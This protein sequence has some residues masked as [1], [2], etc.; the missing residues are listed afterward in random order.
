MVDIDK[1]GGNEG[2]QAASVVVMLQP[3]HSLGLALARALAQEGAHLL[4][5]DRNPD[6]GEIMAR[7]LA[8]E[9]IN[10]AFRLL[11]TSGTGMGGVASDLRKVYGQIEGV[12]AFHEPVARSRKL[13]WLS[14][15]QHVLE[16]LFAS[17]VG[18]RLKFY[19]ALKNGFSVA[20]G[21]VVNVYMGESDEQWV[22]GMDGA[23]AAM[24]QTL[25]GPD[26]SAHNVPI[27][28]VEVANAGYLDADRAAANSAIDADLRAVLAAMGRCEPESS[29]LITTGAD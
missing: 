14:L 8:L 7:R 16:H 4:I 23:A 28:S 25:V 18:W 22:R 9:G 17:S 24:V 21:Y 26:F 6:Q 12:V 15:P 27:S 3:C 2:E 11:D 10:V 19:R 5:V 13:D 20:G 1:L 29:Q